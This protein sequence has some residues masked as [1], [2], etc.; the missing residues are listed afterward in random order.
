[1]EGRPF[2]QEYRLRRPDGGSVWLR[3]EAVLVRS[4][5]GGEPFWQGVVVDVT[6]R[7]TAERQIEFLA[8]H[9]NLT[10]LPNRAL[11]E[12][13]LAQSLQRARRN[14]SAVALLSLDVDG[15]KLV[16]DA[17]GHDAGDELLRMTAAALR[18]SIR[19]ADV[20]ARVGGDEFA[21]LASD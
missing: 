1:A 2:L 14:G 13:L 4:A 21:A 16:N 6:A 19:T 18:A 11:L 9:D 17:L 15:L 3:D 8:F 5:D 20:A 12:Q 10:E 7:R